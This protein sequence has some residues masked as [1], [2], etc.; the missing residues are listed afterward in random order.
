M[1]LD[2]ALKK[3]EEYF[4]EKIETYGPTPKG[5][6]Y[7]GL[8]AQYIRFEQLIKI[9]NPSQRFTIIDYGCGYGALFDYLQKQAW[10]FEYFG[11][12]RLEKMVIAGREAHKNLPNIHF[13]QTE[14]DLAVA[15]Y[16]IAGSIFNN[17]FGAKDDE[18]TKMVLETL[19]KMNKLC[20]TGFSF[21]MLTKYADADRMALRPDLYFADPL[22]IF[23]FCKKN[24][25]RNVALLHDYNLYDFTIL[26]RKVL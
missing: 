16:L 25:S 14:G 21:N 6:D 19:L 17:K 1:S 8:D 11:Y 3:Y 5:T 24:F 12:D 18:W 4:N 13:Q 23:D 10:Q 22:F 15:D 26:V 7:N 2:Q 9:I 20:N